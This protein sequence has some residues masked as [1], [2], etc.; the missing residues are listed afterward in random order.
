MMCRMSNTS[1]SNALIPIMFVLRTEALRLKYAS[2]FS[3]SLLSLS[4]SSNSV[5]PYVPGIHHVQSYHIPS[6][7]LLQLSCACRQV[8]SSLYLTL[9]IAWLPTSCRA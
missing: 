2:L 4:H 8:L 9:P 3:G 5:A 7:L 1:F 6:H